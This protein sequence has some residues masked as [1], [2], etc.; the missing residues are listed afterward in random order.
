MATSTLQTVEL[1]REALLE[2]PVPEVEGLVVLAALVEVV[3]M[4]VQEEGTVA[5]RANRM[6]RHDI[7][8]VDS[9]W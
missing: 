7:C 8:I 2:M 3:W 5:V 9:C 4:A 1:L 6:S